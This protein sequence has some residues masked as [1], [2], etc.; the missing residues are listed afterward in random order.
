MALAV[1]AA[2]DP[3][4]DALLA[5]P[6]PFEQLPD[7]LRRLADGAPGPCHLVSYDPL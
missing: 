3:A 7:L 4:L 1:R 5:G 2:A 6:T